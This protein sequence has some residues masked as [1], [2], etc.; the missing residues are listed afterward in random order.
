MPSILD[1][2]KIDDF[3]D[4]TDPETIQILKAGK[5]YNLDSLRDLLFNYSQKDQLS[6]YIAYDEA[7]KARDTAKKS[8]D[9][10]EQK[11]QEKMKLYADQQSGPNADPDFDPVKAIED[12]KE[13]LDDAIKEFED[14]E[15]E[16]EKQ[17][18]L[19]ASVRKENGD[20]EAEKAFESVKKL[21]ADEKKKIGKELLAIIDKETKILVHNKNKI[22]LMI[23]FGSK[24]S[25]V[26]FQNMVSG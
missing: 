18:K 12:E 23:M 10:A 20:Y 14:A 15:K 9:K 16:L 19:S 21:S 3:I 24:L 13:E 4:I 6:K 5:F 2:I 7:R 25:S 26:V 1:V 22:H 11:L 17:M 8:F